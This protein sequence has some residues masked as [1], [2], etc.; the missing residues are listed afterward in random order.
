MFRADII[1][2]KYPEYLSDISEVKYLEN[3]IE[4]KGFGSYSSLFN[5]NITFTSTKDIVETRMKIKQIIGFLPPIIKANNGKSKE[6]RV[7]VCKPN[8]AVEQ[9]E[10]L[11]DN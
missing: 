3:G 5:D 7:F 8:I 1:F 9:I 6:T 11:K 2:R 10:L 4:Q